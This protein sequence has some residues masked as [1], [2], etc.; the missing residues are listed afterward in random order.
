M[1]VGHRILGRMDNTLGPSKRRLSLPLL[2]LRLTRHRLMPQRMVF[3]PL[4]AAVVVGA[5]VAVVGPIPTGVVRHTEAVSVEE[6]EAHLLP[7]C[8]LDIFWHL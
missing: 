7:P 4:G 1:D 3:L 2:I 6:D 8:L 5:T